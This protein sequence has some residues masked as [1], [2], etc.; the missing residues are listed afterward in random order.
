MNTQ[1]PQSSPP[2]SEHGDAPMM[3]T[4]YSRI[5]QWCFGRLFAGIDYP[6]QSAAEINALAK[7]GIV[8]YVARAPSA[9]LYL[10]LNH[11]L[12]KLGLPLAQYVAGF[13]FA[14]W[15]P[16]SKLWR[17]WLKRSDAPQGP[18]RGS[19]QNTSHGSK[20]LGMP[21]RSCEAKLHF[22]CFN[23]AANQNAP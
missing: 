17:W 6:Q 18:W 21:T 19:Y 2:T 13:S 4:R 12:R 15:Q 20:R 23:L 11:A 9:W 10:Y 7:D 16:V 8:V 14:L 1:S 3:H 22:S 5:L